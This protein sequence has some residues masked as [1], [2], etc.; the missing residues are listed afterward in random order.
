MELLTLSES[1]ENGVELEEVNDFITKPFDPTLIRVESKTLSVDLLLTRIK[2]GE[3]NLS[4]SF[5]RMAD[6]WSPTAQSRL[7]ESLL[8]RI[9][10]PAFYMDATDENSWLV[11]D[12]LQRLTA[13]KKFVIDKQLA[14][15]GLEFLTQLNGSRFDELPRF[16]KRRINETQ[17]TVFLIEKGTPPDV[18]FNIF[19]RI[20]TGG[21]PLS[22][23]E[24]RHA[25][26][27]GQVT[28]LLADLASSEEFLAA[29]DRGINSKRMVD[30]ECVLRFIAFTLTPPTDYKTADFDSFLNAAMIE[31]NHAPR[32]RLER[33]T[34][35]FCNAMKAAHHIFDRQAFRKIS[36]GRTGRSLINKALFETW[37]VNLAA[38]SEDEVARLVARKDIVLEKFCALL[39]ERDF[40]ASISQGT[41]DPS[42]VRTRFSSIQKLIQQSLL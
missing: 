11:V 27:Q 22:P 33:L 12:G 40:E 17:I 21:L 5:Q 2:E 13:L 6:I 30:R 29:T 37:S 41:G 42:R 25:L 19:K 8:I 3:I 4:P 26:N 15:I 36:A 31:I 10:L 38:L 18:K 35:Q 39:L 32:N 28:T 9:P 14:L 1:D 24:I 20:N 7:V 23:Q 34:R 16:L